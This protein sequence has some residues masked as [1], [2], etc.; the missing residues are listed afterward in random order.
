MRTPTM[1]LLKQ[2]VC[3]LFALIAGCNQT[4]S[5]SDGLKYFTSPSA[6]VEQIKDMLEAKNW[7]ELAKY[8]DLADSPIDRADLVSG[9]F[10]YTEGKPEVAHPAG[11]WKYKHPFAPAFEF[12]STRELEDAG[13]IEVTVGVEIDQGGGMIQRGLQTFL[14]RKSNKGY[15]VLPRKVPAP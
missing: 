12:R 15:Q 11:F 14:M 6:G 2:V 7:A 5:T 8:Y 3:L 13:V 4:T 9:D 1:L 10:F